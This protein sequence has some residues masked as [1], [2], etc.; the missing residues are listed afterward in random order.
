MHYTNTKLRIELEKCRVLILVAVLSFH[1]THERHL[2]IRCPTN[3]YKS[4][5]LLAIL[6]S[7]LS[8][9]SP[10]TQYTG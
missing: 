2:V 3:Y 6:L 4:I 9:C 7:V 8:P 1:T 5:V 10:Q